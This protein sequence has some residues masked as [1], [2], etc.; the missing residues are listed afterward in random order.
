MPTIF[1]EKTEKERRRLFLYGC[2]P[3]RAVVYFIV[4]AL[5]VMFPKILGPI[6]AVISI[7]GIGFMTYQTYNSPA[8]WIRWPHILIWILVGVISILSYFYREISYAIIPVLVIDWVI[9]VIMY[10]IK[11]K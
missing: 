5:L 3:V 6:L 10:S 2:L 8:W 4:A 7:F 11:F 1:Q 9:A